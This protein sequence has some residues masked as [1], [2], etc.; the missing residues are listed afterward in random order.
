MLDVIKKAAVVPK[1]FLNNLNLYFI[2]LGDFIEKKLEYKSL[3]RVIL[4]FLMP[5]LVL[6]RMHF[7]SLKMYE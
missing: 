7:A 6:S 3:K 4:W 5:V 1:N 2:L